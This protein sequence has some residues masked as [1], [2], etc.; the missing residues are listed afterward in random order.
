MQTL[1]FI[2][3]MDSCISEEFLQRYTREQ[4]K[5]R[6]FSLPVA[7]TSKSMRGGCW[8]ALCRWHVGGKNESMSSGMALGFFYVQEQS[9][10]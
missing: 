4:V 3:K 5:I 7:M 2:E 1:V 10:S 8:I 6:G 9:S